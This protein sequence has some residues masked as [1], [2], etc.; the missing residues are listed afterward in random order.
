MSWSIPVFLT[1]PLWFSFAVGLLCLGIGL[2]LYLSFKRIGQGH[3]WRKLAV[4]LLNLTACVALLGLLTDITL[5]KKT[6]R[7]AWLITDYASPLNAELQTQFNA[8]DKNQRFVLSSGL[9]SLNTLQLARDDVHEIDQP[10]QLLDWQPQLQQLTLIGEGLNAAQWQSVF[11]THPQL[12]IRYIQPQR[13]SGLVDMRWSRQLI[14]GQYL[15]ISGRVQIAPHEQNSADLYKLELIDSMQQVLHTLTLRANEPFHFAKPSKIAGN[16]HYSLQLSQPAPQAASKK[17]FATEVINVSVEPGKSLSVLIYQSAPSFETRQLKEWLTT[18]S[19]PV[20]VITQVSQ[21]TYL[22]QHYNYSET[23][24]LT[25]GKEIFRAESLADFSLV[26]MDGRAFSALLKNQELALQQ[27]IENGLG[28]L[29]LAD[30]TLLNRLQQSPDGLTKAWSLQA[31]EQ[32]NAPLQVLPRWPDSALQQSIQIPALQLTMAAGQ[33]LVST[34]NQQTLVGVSSFGLGQLALSLIN[35]S[36]QWQTSGNADVYSHYWQLLLSKLSRNQQQAYWLKN[37]SDKLLFANQLTTLCAVSADA[38]INAQSQVS[39]QL[40][41]KPLVFNQDSIQ[42]DKHC[43]LWWP[44][45]LGWQQLH[46]YNAHDPS[47][48]HNTANIEKGDLID[49]Q[50]LFVHSAKDWQAWQ[51]KDKIDSSVFHSKLSDNA[52]APEPQLQHKPINKLWCWLLL[53]MSCSVLWVERKLFT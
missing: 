46:L 3:A 5:H 23:H 19:H 40:A 1:Q 37:A 42:Q 51:Q 13:L 49:S 27:A 4:M 44:D 12:K 28:L 8:L 17:P 41:Q 31:L 36:Y 18:F 11:A 34:D 21:D 9:S 30:Q 47:T 43:A 22:T 14:V 7:K 32:Q 38:N 33:T 2:S 45:T 50:T 25:P 48:G 26:V 29:I 20:S 35:Q 39:G 24:T 6:V 53:L 16:W 52:P 15:D 10:E